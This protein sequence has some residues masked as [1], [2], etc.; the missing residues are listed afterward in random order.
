MCFI[1]TLTDEAAKWNIDKIKKKFKLCTYLRTT[2]MHLFNQ[3]GRI[4]LY[5][6]TNRII[7]EFASIRLEVYAQHKVPQ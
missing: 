2:N 6:S 1:V 5:K 3:E 4:V 7:E